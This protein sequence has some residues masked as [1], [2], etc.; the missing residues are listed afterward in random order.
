[1]IKLP[2]LRTIRPKR[3]A[4]R[5]IHILA[6]C[7]VVGSTGLTGCSAEPETQIIS[8]LVKFRD[9]TEPARSDLDQIAKAYKS[10]AQAEESGILGALFGIKHPHSGTVLLGYL[11]EGDCEFALRKVEDSLKRHLSAVEY[12]RL[13]DATSFECT[14][15]DAYF[16]QGADNEMAT[17]RL[18]EVSRKDANE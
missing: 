8:V 13:L 2:W 16:E 11:V 4:I 14:S 7:L 12:E 9:E 1:M 15:G 10:Q 5:R 17:I 6:C 3:T 18:R